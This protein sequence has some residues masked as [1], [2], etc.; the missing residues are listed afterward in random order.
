MS[1]AAFLLR[2]RRLFFHAKQRNDY[3]Y[4]NLIENPANRIFVAVIADDEH[5]G[6][7]RQVAARDF[8]IAVERRIPFDVYNTSNPVF[9]DNGG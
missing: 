4:K 6:S 1:S 9:H 5:D 2:R 7:G 8:L 3:A